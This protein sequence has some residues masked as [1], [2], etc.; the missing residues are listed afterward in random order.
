MAHFLFGIEAMGTGCIR[1]CVSDVPVVMVH[2]LQSESPVD[3]RV[4]ASIFYGSAEEP[5][6][7]LSGIINENLPRHV[8]GN[9]LRITP[10][11]FISAMERVCCSEATQ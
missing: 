3:L 10:R 6:L 9:W 8:R 11:D 7:A 1:V 4:V 5:E 2:E